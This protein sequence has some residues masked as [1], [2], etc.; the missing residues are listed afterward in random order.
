[1]NS[2][3]SLI[4]WFS[5]HPGVLIGLG[6]SSILIFIISILGISWFVAQIPEDYFLSSKR[7]PSKWQEQKPIL[8]LAVLFGKNIIGVS[9]IIGG[10][11]MLVLPGQGLLTIVTGLLLI[12]YPGKYKLEQKLVAIPSV[13]RALNWIRVKA[14][15]P[16]LKRK[17]VHQ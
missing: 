11:L 15:K 12:N 7:K 5:D 9:L 4:L 6:A 8:R 10:L 17:T 13:F 14:N 2:I 16:P 1:M 3:N